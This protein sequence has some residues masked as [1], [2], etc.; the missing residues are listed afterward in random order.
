VKTSLEDIGPWQKAIAITLDPDE[1][2][3]EM[4]HVVARYR[5]KAVIPGFRKGKV[6]EQIVRTQFRSSLESDLLNHILPEATEKAVQE[7]ALQL[8][9]PPK[10]QDLRFRPGEPL[11][12]TAVVD[13]WPQVTVSGH[14][15]ME[16]EETITAVDEGT[17]EEFLAALRERMAELVPVFRASVEG[18]ILEVAIQ[19]VDVNGQRLPR[20]KRQVQRME[21]GSARLLPEFREV[22]IG[23]EPGGTAVVHVRYPEDFENADLAGK[24]RHYQLRVRQI[25]EKKLPELDD[26]F[27][28]KVDGLESLEALRSKI[29]LRLETE[30]R[31]RA[32][33]RT[34]EA[35]I[36]RLILNN[37]LEVPESIIEASLERALA[38]AQEREPGVD[39]EEFRRAYRPLVA[40][41]RQR[42]ILLESLAQQEGIEVTEEEVLAEVAQASPPGV[43]PRVVRQRLERDGELDRIRGDLRERKV[44]TLLT[45]NSTI[46]R[47]HQPSPRQP[48][49]NLILP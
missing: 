48:K 46:H 15:G 9:A 16:I 31:L 13:V 3:R 44:L 32:R 37:P 10:I 5:E 8:A 6:P 41:L 40:R 43:N 23:L 49:S 26:A 11:Q 38:K 29:R 28:Q 45:E 12:F 20:A 21:A 47:I 33:Q 7:H 34:E 30:E 2:E 25:M 4:D 39:E 1:V 22:S 36:D 24:Q 19:A 35:L 18:D 14:K 42:E 17:V 27:A